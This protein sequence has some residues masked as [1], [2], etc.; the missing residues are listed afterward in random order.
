MPRSVNLDDRNPDWL[1]EAQDALKANVA[2]GVGWLDAAP[3]IKAAMVAP[4]IDY[5][6]G[7][8]AF[9]KLAV[10]SDSR[11]GVRELKRQLAEMSAK[12][13]E[14][15]AALRAGTA[16]LQQVVAAFAEP[17]AQMIAATEAATIANASEQ[18]EIVAT[19]VKIATLEQTIA[20]LGVEISSGI[21]DDEETIVENQIDIL[22][23]VAIGASEIPFVGI[24]L[25]VIS[26]TVS[27]VEDVLSSVEV[28]NALTELRQALADQFVEAQAA[29]ALHAIL[30]AFTRL[31][32]LYER[33]MQPGPHLEM[34][35]EREK[36][37]L[38]RIVEALDA[39]A[40]PTE[41]QDL[42]EPGRRQRDM[43]RTGAVR[44][45]T[46]GARHRWDEIR[47][48]SR[49]GSGR[50]TGHGGDRTMTD[51]VPIPLVPGGKTTGADV[52]KT[53]G[54]GMASIAVVN[55]YALSLEQLAIHP[56][57]TPPPDW[58]DALSAKL[59]IAKGHGKAWLQTS[60]SISS[61]IPTTIIEFGSEFQAAATLIEAELKK[62]D[63]LDPKSKQ[64]ADIVA[65]VKVYLGGLR[66]KLVAIDAMTLSVA[67][68]LNTAQND[69]AAD[70]EA[71]TTGVDTN[72]GR[73]DA[74]GQADQRYRKRYQDL[75]GQDRFREQPYHGFGDR[76]RPWPADVGRRD[77]P[78]HRRARDRRAGRRRRRRHRGGRA[79]R[80]HR[81]GGDHQEAAG[82]DRRQAGRQG[83]RRAPDRHL[84]GTQHLHR[85]IEEVQRQSAGRDGRDTRRMESDRPDAG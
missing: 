71:L 46:A 80:D 53:M 6:A 21:I 7:F 8:A 48:A 17:H 69:A 36:D 12:I 77:R 74:S 73:G 66:T 38:A 40:R 10:L 28:N 75:A 20:D 35:W 52:R 68:Q 55:A 37:K 41:M 49:I 24:G 33:A 43:G 1:T 63:G 31:D 64:Y 18:E 85:D 23:G 16:P 11:D 29:S 32:D 4:L 27:I 26:L 67:T 5:A 2:A 44:R 81:A 15:L 13:D 39:H 62:A 84:A 82:K 78:V 47:D 65:Q 3:A 34:L 30:G 22:Y 59:D 9:A 79:R 61:T 60:T 83:R 42:S 57:T 14:A 19:A 58:F 25:V 51:N 70:F 76:L 56:P 45:E 50:S 54:S 72:S